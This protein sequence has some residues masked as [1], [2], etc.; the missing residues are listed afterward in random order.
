MCYYGLN[1][2]LVISQAPAG[3]PVETTLTRGWVRYAVDMGSLEQCDLDFEV[4][5]LIPVPGESRELGVMIRACSPFRNLRMY[6]LIRKKMTNKCEN[7][8]EFLSEASRLNSL[9]TRLRIDIE[10]RCNML[11]RCSYCEWEFAKEMEKH[12]RLGEPLSVLEELEPLL[13]YAEEVVD[14]SIGEPFLHPDLGAILDKIADIGAHMEMT[15]N[16]HL[17]D[18]KNRSK[19]FGKDITLYVSVDAATEAGYR[20][21]RHGSLDRILKN[22]KALSEERRNHKNLPKI[23]VSFIAM[24][25]N[26]AEF[27]PFLDRMAEIGVDG[28][29]V[30]SLYEKPQM[31]LDVTELGSRG[32]DYQSEILPLADHLRFL[33]FAEACAANK[34]MKLISEHDFC[35]ELDETVGPICNEPWQS[36]H[37]LKR[38][39]IPC[40]FSRTPL[41]SWER[42]GN[43]PL[44]QF[45]AEVW[46]GGLMREMREALA[47]GEFHDMCKMGSGC[48]IVKRK[49]F[50]L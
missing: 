20:R 4:T 41:A 42:R 23:A 11:P 12:S 7:V 43:R 32:F 22:V 35:R 10:T 31:P 29:K 50:G 25:S 39:L 47:V 21:F 27:E 2:K 44:M 13:E 1:G 19:L 37:V 16:G 3:N 30:R 28:V 40:C 9:P 38:G 15:S 49:S 36:L 45:V 46:N 8:R 6:E 33:D 17:L 24:R 18:R 14:C 5:P 34:G 48:P 26:V